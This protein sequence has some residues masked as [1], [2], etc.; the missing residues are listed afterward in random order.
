CVAVLTTTLVAPF[1]PFTPLSPLV[2]FAPARPCWFHAMADSP[3][4]R[5]RRLPRL[6]VLAFRHEEAL[7]TTRKAP[8]VATQPWYTPLRSGTPLSA[9][10]PPPSATNSAPVAITFA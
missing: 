6:T 5:T 9:Y 4:I 7:A 2:P 10:A 3:G 1:A 8:D